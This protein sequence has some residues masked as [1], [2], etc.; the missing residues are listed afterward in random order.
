MN[1]GRSRRGNKLA[2]SIDDKNKNMIDVQDQAMN[3]KRSQ[4]AV[5]NH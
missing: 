4:A 5:G 1:N 2:E 3:R